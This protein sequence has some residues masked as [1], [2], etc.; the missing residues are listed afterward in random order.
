MPEAEAAPKLAPVASA[1]SDGRQ[2]RALAMAEQ[3]LDTARQR[4]R[5]YRGK[6]EHMRRK[7]EANLRAAE[8]DVAILR[9]A[10]AD[11]GNTQPVEND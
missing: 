11:A 2:A 6:S 3:R 7:L 8:Y 5:D 4:R 1:I 10:L 9:Y